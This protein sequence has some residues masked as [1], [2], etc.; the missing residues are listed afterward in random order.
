MKYLTLVRKILS[1]GERQFG[2]EQKTACFIKQSLETRKID[3]SSQVFDT[4]SPKIQKALLRVDGENLNCEGTGFISG[5]V[6]PKK[7]LNSLESSQPHLYDS[8]INSNPDC[9]T[10]SLSNF[11][12]APSLAICYRDRNKIDNN[13]HVEASLKVVPTKYQ[14]EN[15]L[16]G[17]SKNPEYILTGHYD[18]IK[19]GAID[20]ASGTA[21][22]LK[23]ILDHPSLLDKTLFVFSGNEELSYDQPIYWGHG[24]R[25]FEEKY[26]T[27]LLAA[28]KIFIV[29]CVG[30]ARTEQTS[31][32]ETIAKAFPIINIEKIKNKVFAISGSIASLMRCYHAENDT[33]N[34]LKEVYLEDTAK[35]LLKKIK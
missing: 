25:V 27:Q 20:N 29:D 26:F 9:T 35:F 2:S 21:V 4:F 28:K 33:I 34:G 11:Y 32:P 13:A 19:T 14:S 6:N 10:I 24:Y 1:F 18:S 31:A 16:V 30:N 17:N 12:F 8:N 22:M 23:L 7:F 5:K 15:I 3:F